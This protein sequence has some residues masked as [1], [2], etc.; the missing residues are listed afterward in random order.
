MSK[1]LFTEKWK[2]LL[3]KL[4]QKSEQ[5]E[6]EIE[7]LKKELAEK[8]SE[9]AKQNQRAEDLVKRLENLEEN[10]RNLNVA[11]ETDINSWTGRIEGVEVAANAR[12]AA[13]EAKLGELDAIVEK[14]NAQLS[15]LEGIRLNLRNNNKL[16]E[17]CLAQ[18]KEYKDALNRITFEAAKNDD[19]NT[20]AYGSIDYFDFEN[21]FRGSREM[22]K[23]NQTSYVKY[24]EGCKHVVDIGCGRGEFLELMKENGIGAVGVDTYTEFVEFCKERDL[25]VVEQD[26]IE[27]LLNCDG[28]DGIFAGQLVEHLKVEQIIALCRVAYERLEPGKCLIMETPNPMSLAI[29]T[30]AFYLDP[31]HMKPVHPLLLQYIAAKAGFSKVDIIFTKESRLDMEIPKLEIEGA[32]L[33]QYNKA[34]A[35]VSNLLFGSQ[36]YAIV[37]YK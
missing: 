4:Q 36:D 30:H 12:L 25:N 33:V 9:L 18:T 32:D 31:S 26:A 34:M 29:Y 35:E 28:T 7:L 8:E 6:Q 13:Q 23:S 10:V 11:R 27:Y 19:S 17:D 3:E 20:N 5:N 1:M 37:A 15:D 21:H 24:F 2:L 14:V 16:V 22:I